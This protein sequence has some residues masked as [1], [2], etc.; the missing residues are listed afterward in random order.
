MSSP[1]GGAGAA[2]P[3]YDRYASFQGDAVVVSLNTLAFVRGALFSIDPEN[4]NVVLFEWLQDENKV[5]RTHTVMAHAIMSIKLDTDEGGT[6]INTIRQRLAATMPSSAANSTPVAIQQYLQQ[7]CI[8]ATIDNVSKDL[9][10]FGGAATI[11]PPYDEFS[12]CATNG[13]VL[14][15]LTQLLRLCNA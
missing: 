8:E 1:C 2:H 5:V 10:V 15:R 3:M 14:E 12:V 9:I 6:D 7:H 11:A 4:G 13:L